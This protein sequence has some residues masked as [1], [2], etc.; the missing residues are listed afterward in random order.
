MRVTVQGNPDYFHVN[1]RQFNDANGVETFDPKD[2]ALDVLAKLRA[3]GINDPK[4]VSGFSFRKSANINIAPGSRSEPIEIGGPGEIT[5][6]A[7]PPTAPGPT[8]SV[9]GGRWQSFHDR[10]PQPI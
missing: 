9:R 2:K 4:N 10:W 3:F 8:R 6:C 1:Y 5:N 7:C